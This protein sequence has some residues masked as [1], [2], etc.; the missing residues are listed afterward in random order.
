MLS[1]S[2]QE[3]AFLLNAAGVAVGLGVSDGAGSVVA[4]GVGVGVAVALGVTGTELELLGSDVGIASCAAV[5][6]ARVA[7]RAKATVAT[8]TRVRDST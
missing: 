6:P 5:H 4:V 1:G 2:F 3:C 8:A 7:A